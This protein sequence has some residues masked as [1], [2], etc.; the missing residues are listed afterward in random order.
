MAKSAS[1][2]EDGDTEKDTEMKESRIETQRSKEKKRAMDTLEHGDFFCNRAESIVFTSISQP[3]I[4]TFDEFS[5]QHVLYVIRQDKNIIQKRFDCPTTAT[6]AAA[7]TTEPIQCGQA[8]V[9]GQQGAT[10]INTSKSNE[11]KTSFS[12]GEEDLVSFTHSPLISAKEPTSDPSVSGGGF[13]D[14]LFQSHSIA[15]PDMSHIS[16]LPAKSMVVDDRN[17]KSLIHSEIFLECFWKENVEFVQSYI[18][19]Q[20]GESLA[21]TCDVHWNE[22]AYV[23]FAND[24]YNNPLLCFFRFVCVCV[25]IV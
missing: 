17:K 3:M 18:Q 20:Y 15:N 1:Y 13:L 4:I 21:K 25:C 16:S 7:T 19:Q 14:G 23:F 6:A 12:N 8:Q 11:K 5:K 10:V 22:P 2:S 24:I 9:G